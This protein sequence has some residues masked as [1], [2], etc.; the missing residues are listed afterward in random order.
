MAIFVSDMLEREVLEFTSS[1]NS[2]GFPT[3]SGGN[4][5]VLSSLD[6]L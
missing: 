3:I 6:Y 2:E 5:L 4:S 1:K